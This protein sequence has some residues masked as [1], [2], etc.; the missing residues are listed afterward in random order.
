MLSRICILV[1]ALTLTKISVGQVAK[2]NLAA[3]AKYEVTTTT[4]LTSTANVMGQT[5]ET[6]L[7][8]ENLEGFEIKS[9]AANNN[10]LSSVIKRI[11]LTMSMMGQ[12]MN[13]DSDKD[14][15]GDIADQVGSK[16]NK[17]YTVLYDDNGKILNKDIVAAAQ[18][19]AMVPGMPSSGGKASLIDDRFIGREL[20]N[21][22]TWYDSTATDNEKMKTTVKGNYKVLSVQ[23]DMAT[24]IFEGTQSQNGVV[25]QM[26]MEMN[27][28]GTSN[29]TKEILL[30]LKTGLVIQ[31]NTKT[32]GTSNIEVMGSSIPVETDVTVTKKIKLLPN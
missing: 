6:K 16:V 21:G 2:I 8:T 10:E 26:G 15:K 24:I 20:K 32:K 23:N 19:D 17:P 3:G 13:Y 11:K 28:S 30:D 29:V 27:M 22:T 14:T 9:I 4:K 31:A 7:D 5:M 12:D 18:P 25:E 1:I